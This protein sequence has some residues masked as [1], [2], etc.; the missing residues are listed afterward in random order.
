MTEQ[1]QQTQTTDATTA[2]ST[3]DSAATTATSQTTTGTD[4]AV[5]DTG[6]N[7]ESNQTAAEADGT[8][9]GAPEDYADFELPEGALPDPELM[10]EYKKAAKEIGL[11]Q[12]QAQNLAQMGAKMAEKITAQ[13]M[14]A[15]EQRVANWEA[16][17]KADPEIGGEQ[18][19]A[20]LSVIPPVLKAF[21]S[22]N[23]VNFMNETGIGNHPEFVK[24]FVKV[25]KAMSED[26]LLPG[27]STTPGGQ[28]TLAQT[29]YPNMNP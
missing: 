13:A 8:K 26:T 20:N 16:E 2:T 1:T 29:L 27:G 18:L 22:E 11:T 7:T 6:T 4:A 10:T 19:Q 23:L 21:G 17:T 15:H 28:K 12:E 5:T 24:F 25:G 3:V 14:A 9:T